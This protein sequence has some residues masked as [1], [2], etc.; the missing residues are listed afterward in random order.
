MTAVVIDQR[1]HRP[2]LENYQ[3]HDLYN[4]TIHMMDAI[5]LTPVKQ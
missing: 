4:G 2:Y 3:L 5:T 1:S